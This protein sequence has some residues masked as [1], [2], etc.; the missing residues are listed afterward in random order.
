MGLSAQVRDVN[1]TCIWT[2]QLANSFPTTPTTSKFW[3]SRSHSKPCDTLAKI[4]KELITKTQ[5]YALW[6]TQLWKV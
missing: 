4:I 2:W 1:A 6:Y 3:T 5:M